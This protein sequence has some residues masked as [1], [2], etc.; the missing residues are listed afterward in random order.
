MPSVP[1]TVAVCALAMLLIAAADAMNPEELVRRGNA[2]FDRQEYEAAVK[3]FTEAEPL[4]PN[5]GIVAHNK[6]AALY[7]LGRFAEAQLHYERCLE[8]AEPHQRAALQFDLANC[9]L[10]QAQA[11]SNGKL[12]RDTAAAYE[13]CLAEPMI[14][15][16]LKSSA[17]HN[18]EL[19]KLLWLQARLAR[20]GQKEPEPGNEPRNDP[21]AKTPENPEKPDDGGN[22]QSGAT[23]KPS[24]DKDGKTKPETKDGKQE[25]IPTT[26]RTAGRG[27]EKALPPDKQKL[28]PVP[29]ETAL[30]N[31]KRAAEKIS[32]E[33]T[34]YRLRAA[35]APTR[36]VPD[37]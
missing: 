26:E 10:Q 13:R 33:R 28:D 18:L 6:A 9:L 21:P 34:L 5:P 2:A 27:N 29:V 19:A 32:D 35:P 37:W 15:E 17:R 8:E 22:S 14:A 20:A 36:D 12:F 31:L 11:S 7:R 25:P 4:I 30:K 1:Q 23:P 16:E 24:P 3:L